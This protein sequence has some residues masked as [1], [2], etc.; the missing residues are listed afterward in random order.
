M[1]KM[2]NPQTFLRVPQLNRPLQ[3]TRRNITFHRRRVFGE[4][5]I[6][7]RRIESIRQNFRTR[8]VFAEYCADGSAKR[9]ADFDAVEICYY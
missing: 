5:D 6:L 3:H 4:C 2:K 7:I 9:F 1:G 8:R